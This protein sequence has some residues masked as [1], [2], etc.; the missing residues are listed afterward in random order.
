LVIEKE[1][2]SETVSC[3]ALS[4]SDC[5]AYSSEP[6]F[7]YLL[8]VGTYNGS[9]HIYDFSNKFEGKPVSRAGKGEIEGEVICAICWD[10]KEIKI[11]IGTHL[12]NIYSFSVEK[13]EPAKLLN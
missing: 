12:G 11:Y 1:L 7:E 8:A 9:F 4:P 5:E 13:L 3:I 10:L 6:C 2:H